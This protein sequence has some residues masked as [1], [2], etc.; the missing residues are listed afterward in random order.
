MRRGHERA[1]QRFNKRVVRS[2]D[3]CGEKKRDLRMFVLLKQGESHDWK[4]LATIR[5]GK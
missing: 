3:K 2:G 4:L 1:R 5:M